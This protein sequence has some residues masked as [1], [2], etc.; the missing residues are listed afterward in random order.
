M[1]YSYSS[2]PGLAMRSIR[3][4]KILIL[5]MKKDA[6]GVLPG[7]NARPTSERPYAIELKAF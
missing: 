3:P 2:G 4:L 1:V 6:V 7:S 5:F